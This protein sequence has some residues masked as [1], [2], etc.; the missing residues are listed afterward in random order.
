MSMTE[1]ERAIKAHISQ[2]NTSTLCELAVAIDV[3][4][5]E[6]EARQQELEQSARSFLG[7]CLPKRFKR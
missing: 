2:M 7:R 3:E 6:R 5:Q 4:L 1:L